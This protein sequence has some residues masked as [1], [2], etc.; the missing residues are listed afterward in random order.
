M[1]P[2][3]Q[4]TNLSAPSSKITILLI[5]R[6]TIPVIILKKSSPQTTTTKTPKQPNPYTNFVNTEDEI[7]NYD[8]QIK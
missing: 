2:F 4:F 5:V 8:F 3:A 6:T 1:F 7:L